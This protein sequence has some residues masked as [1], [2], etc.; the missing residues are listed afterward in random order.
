MI[1]HLDE[2]G[3][4]HGATAA[5][6][7]S[8]LTIF[9]NPVPLGLRAAGHPKAMT[10]RVKRKEILGTG[11]HTIAA[12]SAAAFVDHGEAMRV[13]FDRIEVTHNL[14]ITHAA[15]SPET[16]FAATGHQCRCG[17]R[18]EAAVVSV[19][20]CN[21]RAAGACQARYSLFLRADINPQVRRDLSMICVG[22]HRA[23]SRQNLSLNSPTGEDL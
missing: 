18:L 23:L 14:A 17:A 3:G 2:P 1:L 19:I 7:A 15:A 5:C 4:I 22:P 13:H 21:V 9:E 16:P 6:G 20:A 10:Y 8:D 11:F 12:G